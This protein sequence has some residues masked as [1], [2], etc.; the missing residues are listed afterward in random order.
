MMLKFTPQHSEFRQT[1]IGGKLSWNVA[2]CCSVVVAI[3][4]VVVVTVSIS[5]HI[6]MT[7]LTAHTSV[8]NIYVR[9]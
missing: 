8:P 5:S 4:I 9:F 7:K 1:K 3:V 2:A 6:F